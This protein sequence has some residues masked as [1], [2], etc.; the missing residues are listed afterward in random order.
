MTGE[1]AAL[2]DQTMPP[3]R[4]ASVMDLGFCFGEVKGLF[5][6]ACRLMRF[7]P[8]ICF[9]VQDYP[10]R[11]PKFA[12]RIRQCSSQGFALFVFKR[13]FVG[14]SVSLSVCLSVSYYILDILIS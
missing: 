7:A 6:A 12:P 14:Q 3:F 4:W 11:T 13:V 2:V 10:G 5:W 8:A 9:G 1:S